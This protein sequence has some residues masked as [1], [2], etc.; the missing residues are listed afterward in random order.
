[1]R[2]KA[3]EQKATNV[4]LNVLILRLINFFATF[5]KI[6]RKEKIV[7]G[8]ILSGLPVEETH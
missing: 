1:M 2:S 6:F 5:S 3:N 7:A 4:T 8:P